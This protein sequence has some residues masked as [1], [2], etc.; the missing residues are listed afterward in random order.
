[1]HRKKHLLLILLP[2]LATLIVFIAVNAADYRRYRYIMNLD[3]HLTPADFEAMVQSVKDANVKL[4]KGVNSNRKMLSGPE[5]PTVFGKIGAKTLLI[6]A[7]R[8][9]G[10]SV[11]TGAL[12]YLYARGPDSDIFANPTDASLWI[13]TTENHEKVGLN[14][15]FSGSPKSQTLWVANPAIEEQ[16]NPPNRILA[17]W[18]GR[19]NPAWTVTQDAIIYSTS[20]TTIKQQITTF[21]SDAIKG[22][23]DMISPQSRGK[24][25]YDRNIMDG[26]EIAIWF[27]PDGRDSPDDIIVNNS[28]CP[29]LEPLLKMLSKFAPHPEE[30][31]TKKMMVREF[32]RLVSELEKEELGYDPSE[33]YVGDYQVESIEKWRAYPPLQTDWWIVWPKLFLEKPK[34]VLEVPPGLK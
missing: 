4:T 3:K 2:V 7:E 11:H 32:A 14:Q 30:L 1:M 6:F 31:P 9:A 8:H 19:G 25:F 17:L 12:T 13:N 26:A 33:K 28:W 5:I 23:I 15:N 27:S 24:R 18:G 21:Q 29:E 10:G 20:G 16:A 22:A 34:V